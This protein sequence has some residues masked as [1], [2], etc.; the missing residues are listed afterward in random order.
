M[1][2]TAY[3]LHEYAT[4]TIESMNG[5]IYTL[6]IWTTI[7]GSSVPEY[8]LG[9]EG[10]V[11]SYETEDQDDKNSP[12]LSSSLTVPILVEDL[13]QQIAINNF[14]S[15]LPEKSCWIT[16]RRGTSGSYIWCGY[17]IAELEN[18][19][20]TSFPYETKLTAIDGI[21]TLK[22]VP[23]LRETNS[24]TGATPTFPYV[25]QDTW[26][27]AGYQR[28]IGNSNSWF[29]RLIDN[30]GQLLSTDDTGGQLDNYT[31]QTAFNWWNEDMSGSP[32]AGT[33]PLAL[34]QICMRNFYSE[35]ENGSYNVSSVYEVLRSIC[36][37][38]NLRFLYW[39]HT[40][41]FIQ[42]GEYKADEQGSEPYTAPVN[43]P[44]REYFY[45]GGTKA[46]NNYLGNTNYSLYKMKY[47][48]A[49]NPSKGLQ[50]LSGGSYQALP[51]IKKT[52]VSF[53]EKIGPNLFN[54][55]PLF[56]THNTISGISNSYNATNAYFSLYQRPQQGQNYQTMIINDAKDL[57]G[58]LCRIYCDF[59]NTTDSDLVMEVLWTIRAKPQS[60]SFG[61]ADNK[62]LKRVQYTNYAQLEW[63]TQASL[64]LSNN[65]EYIYDQIVVPSTAGLG[66]PTTVE[67]FNSSTSQTTN[68][69]PF[70]GANSGL[71]PVHADFSG[72]WEFELYS[73]TQYNT[74]AAAGER[75]T[76]QGMAANYSH[77]RV[78]SIV[79]GTANNSDGSTSSLSDIPTSY[80]LDYV[81]T[82]DINLNPPFTSEFRPVSTQTTDYNV[83]GTET[84]VTQDSNDTFVY[85]L[86]L[87][88][89]GDTTGATSFSSIKVY[90]GSAWVFTN[91][92]G[93]WAVGSYTWN[94]SAFVYATPTYNKKLIVLL[95]EVVLYQQSKSILRMSGTSALSVNDRYYSGSTKLKYNNPIAKI[96]DTNDDEYIF[97]TGSYNLTK[98]EFSGE[99]IAQS[100]NVPTTV[101][102]GERNIVIRDKRE[103]GSGF[104][105]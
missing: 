59:T 12:I 41:Y 71:I 80:V 44:T 56:V 85:D 46:D 66:G 93:K 3:G 52:I 24:S 68:T 27:N 2:R 100:Y 51:A 97:L 104:I 35:G 11:I 22:E 72:D 39:N 15:S 74:Q 101:L 58:F 18:R 95:S 89:F 73:F 48:N 65:Q 63:V 91:R 8:V 28:L 77:G 55:Y 19:E 40:F 6:T 21:A 86:G 102:T 42:I 83:D 49:T 34:M 50:K 67:I 69:Q 14:R 82:A 9:P 4:S 36:L 98:D 25:R 53:Q 32:A 29:V 62:V 105:P 60:S 92:D 23:F 76:T 79:N 37:N 30:V 45:N 33:D 75:F 10:A 103:D 87:L 81:D 90:N 57:S 84:Q 64:G 1:A 96:L 78:V 13:T 26:D 94:G 54:G 99:Y 31:I 17:V 7:S 5:T 38:F 47:E 70:G 16:I 61:D 20:D 88:N 43:I